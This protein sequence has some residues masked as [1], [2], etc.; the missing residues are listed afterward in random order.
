M[1]IFLERLLRLFRRF[2]RRP[3]AARGSDRDN[4]YPLY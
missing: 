4:M 1:M 3:Q 2:R